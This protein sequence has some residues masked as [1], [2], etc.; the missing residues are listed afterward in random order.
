MTVTPVFRGY[1]PALIT[2][3]SNNEPDLPAF[4]RIVA[5]QIA[6]GASALLIGG[7]T[8]EGSALAPGECSRLLTAAREVMHDTGTALPLIAGAGSSDT[9]SSCS[10]AAEAAGAG[11]NALLTVTP[12]YVK[13]TPN[14]LCHHLQ[15]LHQAS[16]LPIL[17]YHIPSR[18][19]QTLSLPFFEA[20]ARQ[21]PFVTGIKEA[22]G[23]IGL[24]SRLRSVFRD[25]FALY[26]GCDELNYPTL[27]LGADGLISVLALPRP[28]L[29]AALCRAVAENDLEAACELHFRSLPLIRALF[30]QIN[31]VP[32]KGIMSRLGFCS[33]ELRSPLSPMEPS[34]L[35][36]LMQIDGW[37]T[38]K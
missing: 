6:F 10:R 31:P 27:C 14:G 9:A 16:G 22:S 25:R 26:C 19:G 12:P 35:D 18:T 4:R 29:T 11:A 36:A 20:V 17:L 5:M 2:P 3:F 21:C 30:S 28:D 7:T 38:A 32:V 8:G 33:G 13:S 37:R 15:A 34:E 24:F 23:D 1:C